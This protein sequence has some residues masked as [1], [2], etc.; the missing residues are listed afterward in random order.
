MHTK[1]L[2]FVRFVIFFRGVRDEKK[3]PDTP[4]A[5]GSHPPGGAVDCVYGFCHD[6]G[7]PET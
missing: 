4:N 7:Q 5:Y 1:R 6:T 2:I 3:S